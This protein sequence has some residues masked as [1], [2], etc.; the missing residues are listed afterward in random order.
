M[1][2]QSILRPIRAPSNGHLRT[3]SNLFLIHLI[4]SALYFASVAIGYWLNRQKK[5]NQKAA[6][7]GGIA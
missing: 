6:K 5:Y 2:L 7:E 4:G 3:L 1:N